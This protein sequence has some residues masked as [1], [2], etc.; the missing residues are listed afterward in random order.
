M[1]I[2]LITLCF[3]SFD[4]QCD[5]TRTTRFLYYYAA[6]WVKQGHQVL[7]LHSVPCY[8]RFFSQCVDLFENR[9][10][11]DKFQLSKFWQNPE[12]VQKANYEVDGIKVIRTPIKKL[13]P[14][15][16]YLPWQ[17]HGHRKEVLK[18]F[19]N[20]GFEP[21]IILSDFLTPVIY[22]ANDIK[23]LN[24]IPF[25]QVIHLTDFTYLRRK[26]GLHKML[27]QADG[28]LF[29][30]Y[31]HAELFKQEGFEADFMD[32]MFSGV[33]NDMPMG[34]PRTAIKKLLYVG[35]LIPRK[36]VHV[37]LE[38]IAAS[39]ARIHYEIEIVGDGPCESSLK[40]LADK[41]GI[42]NQVVFSGQLPREKVFE[43]MRNAD[44]LVMVSVDTFGMVYIEALSQGC[45]V[46]AAKNQGVDGIIVNGE[47]G[48]L[49]E[50]DD[51]KA[52]TELLDQMMLL[53]KQEIIRITGNGLKTAIEMTDGHLAQKLLERLSVHL[54]HNKESEAI[55]NG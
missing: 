34:L 6:E 52:L 15:H 42:Q 13:V 11:F 5:D 45:L 38:A 31:P 26:T 46:V 47:N 3:P 55:S 33:P 16:D 7:I 19:V 10:G 20:S 43:K 30:S 41:L 36:R 21:D 22:I 24:D 51:V 8:P 28:V 18:Q 49:V 23:R 40:F 14:C 2:L 29:R 54:K 39:K 4:I 50:C 44:S 25:Y 35:R 53:D 17:L 9:L 1:R 37:L 48:F 32:Y 12:M 27:N